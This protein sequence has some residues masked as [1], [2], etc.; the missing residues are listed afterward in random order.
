MLNQLTMSFEGSL[1]FVA[2]GAII[3]FRQAWS[4]L[5]GAVVN[6]VVLAPMMLNAGVIEA[7]VVPQDLLVEPVDRRAHDGDL[8]PPAVLP[9]LEDGRARVQHDRRP[10][11]RSARAATTRWSGSRCRARGSWAASSSSAAP[12]SFLGHLLF[13]IHWWMGVIAVL[14]T[15][16][17]VVVAARARRARPTSRPVGPLSQDHAAHLRRDRARQRHDQ[18][19]D[20][21]HHRRRGVATP[22]TCSPTSRA[23]TCSAPTRASSS[24]PSSSACSPAA[25]VVVPVFFILIPD[26]SVLGTEQWPAP[27]ALV[28]RGVAELLAKGVGALHP[29]AR[30]GLLVG[31]LLGLVLPLLEMRVPEGEE[32]H[33][34]GHRPRARVH[35]QRL[36]HHLDVHRRAASR[37][38]LAQVEAEDR[39]SSTRCR[40]P[41]ASSPARA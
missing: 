9:E 27:A 31:G 2:A 22:A 19:D 11:S 4:M 18:P 12:R 38:W 5:L 13:H 33:P 40:S 23:A 3:S 36:Q 39:T 29:T 34:L 21:Q 30:I 6:Y 26:A 8:G 41:R 15:F 14:A 16:L 37:S 25:L 1:L 7:R 10:S 35:D 32:V 28:W 24:S 20:R 17:L